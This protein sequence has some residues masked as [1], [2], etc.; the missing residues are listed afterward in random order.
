M[1][2]V[3]NCKI[4]GVSSTKVGKYLESIF[5]TNQTAIVSY[6]ETALSEKFA[7]FYK[8]VTGRELDLEKEDIKDLGPKII[9]FHNLLHRDIN[10]TTSFVNNSKFSSVSARELGKRICANFISSFYWQANVIKRY[11]DGK[12]IGKE[13]TKQDYI[14][15]V[16]A[17]IK[18]LVEERYKELVKDE[19]FKAIS[20]KVA[21]DNEGSTDVKRTE[22]M[23]RTHVLF[24]SKLIQD[25]NL[26]A[27]YDE[28]TTSAESKKLFFE[29]VFADNRLSYMS[30]EI[31]DQ[32]VNY[33][34][35]D[36]DDPDNPDTEGKR[37]SNEEKDSNDESTALWDGKL[38]THTNFLKHVDSFVRAYFNSIYKLKKTDITGKSFIEDTD[39]E[40]GIADCMDATECIATIYNRCSANSAEEMI[41]A[42]RLVA[43]EVPGMEGFSTVAD[44]LESNSDMAKYFYTVFGKSIVS[45]NEI[46]SSDGSTGTRISNITA[47]RNQALRMKFFNSLKNTSINNEHKYYLDELENIKN[48]ISYKINNELDR[49]SIEG[50]HRA[51]SKFDLS[52]LESIKNENIKE[53]EKAKHEF[54][55]KK[56]ENLRR[57]LNYRIYE[58]ISKY[59]PNISENTINSYIY[60]KGFDINPETNKYYYIERANNL[61]SLISSL[62]KSAE[63]TEANYYSLKIEIG[64]ARELKRKL[65]NDKSKF[66]YEAV[67]A[68]GREISRLYGESYLTQDTQSAA[69]ALADELIDFMVVRS[70]LNSRN[71]HGN[72]SSDVINNNMITNIIR[73]LNSPGNV[74]LKNFGNYKFKS[75]QY[76]FSN[77]MKEKKE[78]G[79]IVNYGLFKTDDNNELIIGPDGKYVETDYAKDLLQIELFS[80]ANNQDTNTAALYSEMSKGDFVVSAFTAFF[81]SSVTYSSNSEIKFANYFTRIP[82]DAPKIFTIKAPRYSYYNEKTG[83]LFNIK[84]SKELED[85][86]S[87]KLVFKHTLI[88]ENDPVYD[89]GDATKMS[90]DQTAR[91]IAGK[92]DK[93]IYI[94]PPKFQEKDY[95][96]GDTVHIVCITNQGENE[97]DFYYLISATYNKVNGKIELSDIKFEEALDIENLDKAEL[98]EGLDETTRDYLRKEYIANGWN[99]ARGHHTVNREINRNHPIYK[100]LFNLAKQEY[101]DA[102]VAIHKL[103][104][105]DENGVIKP[106]ANLKPTIREKYIN[107][108][109]LTYQ[110]YHHGMRKSPEGNAIEQGII[111]DGK[112]TGKV[113]TSD[114]FTL[115]DEETKKE[116]NYGQEL[117]GR[118]IDFLSTGVNALHFTVDS[119]DRVTVNLTEAQT[120]AINKMLEEYISDYINDCVSRTEQYQSFFDRIYSYE[121]VAE[122]ALNYQLMY[123]NFNDLLEG[124][125]KF[126]KNAQDFLKRAKETQ[127][128]GIPYG[129]ANFNEPLDAPKTEKDS[130]LNTDAIEVDYG[131]DAVKL[132]Y[133]KKRRV[134]LYNRF[135]GVTIKNTIR[136]S[137]DSQSEALISN[138]I[139]SGMT[140]KDA[141]A[142][143]KG[144]RNTKTNDAQSYITY[145]EWIR[146]IVAKGQ[147]AKYANLISKLNAKDKNGNYVPLKVEDID[148]FVQ[149]Q[150]N[151]YYDQHYDEELGIIVPRQIKNAEFVLIP[152]FIQGTELQEVYDLMM[153][154]NIDQL[155][156]QEAS[157]AGKRKVLTIWNDEGKITDESRRDFKNNVDSAKEEYNYNYLYT[158]QETPQ[159]MDSENKAGIQLMKKILDNITEDSP[160]Y[161]HKEKL[162][163]MYCANIKSSFVS[164]M[165]SLH[166]PLDENGNIKLNKVVREHE[167]YNEDGTVSVEEVESY[168]IAGLNTDLLYDRLREEAERLGVNS[169]ELD[170]F[171]TDEFGNPK[172]KSYFS[173][174]DS[175]L[176]SITQS[177]FNSRITKQKLPGFHAA[178]VTSVGWSTNNATIQYRLKESE[179]G[180]GF[181]DVISEEEYKKLPIKNRWRYEKFKGDIGAS[182]ELRYHPD[183]KPYIEVIIPKPAC[184]EDMSDEEALKLMQ[185]EKL[186]EFIGYRIPTEGKQSIA[187]MK[188]VR[189]T[190]KAQGSTIIVPDDWVSQTGADFDIDSVYAI[191]HRMRL[192]NGKLVRDEYDTSDEPSAR[193]RRYANYIA[194]CF[195]DLN[196]TFDYPSYD[197]EQLKVFKDRISLS[198]QDQIDKFNEESKK[199]IDEYFEKEKDL[200][201]NL[202]KE[203]KEALKEL[204]KQYTYVDKKGK[205]HT[206]WTQIVEETLKHFENKELNDAQKEYYE[207]Y[208]A[209]DSI[210]NNR[211]KFFVELGKAKHQ[212]LI[213]NLL[214]LKRK[215]I[216]N[217]VKALTEDKKFTILSFDE[218]INLPIEEQ[219]TKYARDG[220]IIDAMLMIL[221]DIS[222]LEENLSRS[223]FDDIIDARDGIKDKDGNW[224]QRPCMDDAT[225]NRRKSRSSYNFFDQA[226][227]QEDAM[228]GAKLK[229]FSVTQDNFCSI[230]NTVR[231]K[232]SKTIDVL[233][234]G[235]KHK[236]EDLIKTFG[237]DNVRKVTRKNGRTDYVVTHD[238]IGWSLTNKN[239]E[240]K[241]LT[242]YSSQTT[243]HILDAIKEGAIPNVNDL[244]FGVYKLFPN[245]G[246]NYQ[247]AVSFMMQPGVSR[248]VEAY[249][250]NKSIFN[251]DN[252]SVYTEV[253]IK[254]IAQE[255]GVNVDIH[256]PMSEV[257]KGLDVFKDIFIKTFGINP[258]HQ[259]EDSV[260]P[261]KL[262]LEEHNTSE[263]MFSS[264][265]MI[266]RLRN[267]GMFAST[268]P[269]E[270]PIIQQRRLLFDLYVVMQYHRLS[271]ISRSVT[272]IARCTNPDKFGAKQTV[273][274]TRKVISDIKKL[275]DNN[276]L[277]VEKGD[278]NVHIL[279][280]IYPGI[281]GDYASYLTN[282]DKSS[283]P[284]L[285]SFLKYSTVTSILVAEKVFDT[286]KSQFVK[287][288]GDLD[289]YLSGNITEKIY[290]DFQNYILA[291]VYRN[292]DCINGNDEKEV[293]RIC[294]YGKDIDY[295]LDIDFSQDISSKEFDE[296]FEEFKKLTPA[297]KVMLIQEHYREA[298]IFKYLEVNVSNERS[299]YRN[300][301]SEQRITFNSDTVDIEVAL[302]E[303]KK[304]YF[305]EDRIIRNATEDLIKYAIV[306]EGFK[307]RKNGISRSV[308]NDAL[309]DMGFVNEVDSYFKTKIVAAVND[310]EYREKLYTNYIRSHSKMSQIKTIKN[311]RDKNKRYKIP[312]IAYGIIS[313][314]A[315]NS[316]LALNTGIVESI[317]EKFSYP[318]FIKVVN[319]KNVTLYKSFLNSKGELYYYP[320]NLLEENE[321]TTWSSNQ[322]NNIY[323]QEKF[324]KELLALTDKLDVLPYSDYKDEYE[325]NRYV[326]QT[327]NKSIKFNI[328]KPESDEVHAFEQIKNDIIE[329]DREGRVL[330]Y[331][332]IN[333]NVDK[334]FEN[335]RGV[336][337]EQ[338]IDGKTYIFRRKKSNLVK[339]YVLN[340]N[341]DVNKVK[342]PYLR[343]IIEQYREYNLKPNNKSVF[344][345]MQVEHKKE[346]APVVDTPMSS[347]IEDVFDEQ[348]LN[349]QRD[350]IHGDMDAGKNLKLLADLGVTK[351]NKQSISDNLDAVSRIMKDRIVIKTQ[352][353]LG[354]IESFMQLD[355]D[356]Y[357]PIDSDE[358]MEAIK[359]DKKLQNAF[360]NVLLEAE[361]LM[362]DNIIFEHVSADDYEIDNNIKQINNAVDRL[363]KNNTLNNAFVK[364]GNTVVSS[365]S[366]DPLVQAGWLA[367]T[368]GYTNVSKLESWITSAK[369]SGIPVMQIILKEFSS[370]ISSSEFQA[371][372]RV[373]QYRKTREDI[374]NRAKAAG[375]TVDYKNFID[376]NGVFVQKYK[377]ELVDKVN[378]LYDNLSY[379]ETNYGKGSYEYVM[380]YREIA[381]F[382]LEHFNQEVDDKY[383]KT[384]LDLEETMLNR[385]RGIYLE[386]KKLEAERN[387]IYSHVTNNI[388][389]DVYKEKLKQVNDKIDALRSVANADKTAIKPDI[390]E[391]F[392]MTKYDPNNPDHVKKAINTKQHAEA[393]NNYIS[394][395]RRLEKEYFDYPAVEGFYEELK[396]NL[397][398]MYK[399]EKRNSR[400]EIT[401]LP[402]VLAAN[403][404]YMEAK[405]WVEKNARLVIRDDIKKLVDDAFKAFTVSGKTK[406]S[407]FKLLCKQKEAYDK[408]SVVDGRVFT[409]E[410]I[411]SIRDEQIKEYEEKRSSN[412]SDKKL[413]RNNTFGNIVWNTAFY[414]GMSSDSASNDTYIELVIKI[415]K[416]LQK[417][418]D[419]VQ[420]R[421]FTSELSID[422]LEKLEKLYDQLREIKPNHRSKSASKRIA[423]FI[424]ENVEFTHDTITYNQERARAASKGAEYL[425]A[426]DLANGEESEDG[427]WVPTRFL[428]SI[429]MPKG[430]QFE[431][432]RDPK[433]GAITELK[434][435]SVFDR[436]V[437][438]SKTMA[439]DVF[440]KFLSF[441][442]TSYYYQKIDEMIEKAHKANDP[443][444]YQKWY[445]ANHIYNPSTGVME[446]IKCWIKVNYKGA[447]Y[448]SFTSSENSDAVYNYVPSF[449]QTHK[450]TKVRN[451]LYDANLGLLGNYKLNTGYD[452]KSYNLN[453]YEEELRTLMTNTLNEFA[454]TDK[455]SRYIKRGNLPS[456]AR[457]K[458]KTAKESVTKVGK[459]A[460]SL[461]GIVLDDRTNP[462]YH[463]VVDYRHDMPSQVPMLTMLRNSEYK[464]EEK[465][466]SN[467][468]EKTKHEI[469]ERNKAIREHN[470]KIHSDML[471][472][473]WDEVM[474]EFIIRAANYN[475]IQ[476]NKYLLFYAKEMLRKLQTYKTSGLFKQELI[477]DKLRSGE[478]GNE[479]VKQSIKNAED[480]FDTIVRRL[481]YNE[482]KKPQG[483]A[484]RIGNLLQNVSSAKYMMVN[485]TGG[486]AN[487]TYG[488]TQIA[489]EHMFAKTYFNTK[490]WAIGKA[491][492]MQAMSSHLY[493][494]KSGKA[495]N[496]PDG[497]VKL[498]DVIDFDTVNGLAEASSPESWMSTFRSSLYGLQSVGEYFM[499]NGA[500]LSMMNSHRLVLGEDSK[501]HIW[502]LNRYLRDADDVALQQVISENETLMNEY[503]SFKK[504]VMSED[505]IMK[506]YA[507]RKRTPTE[508]FARYILSKNDEMFNKWKELRNKIKKERKESFENDETHPTLYSQFTLTEDGYATFA[509]DSILNDP[510]KIDRKEAFKLLASFRHETISVNQKIHGIYDKIGAASIE[511]EWWG[512]FVMQYHKHLY[513]G[514]MKRFRRKGYFNEERDTIERGCYTALFDF[515]SVEFN[516][517]KY[518]FMSDS[519]R[520]H[521]TGIQNLFKGLTDTI[522]NWK[523]NWSV[524]DDS[525]KAN[526][527]RALND[528]CGWLSAIAISVATRLML[529]DDDEE[530]AEGFCYN[531][532][533]YLAD[534][535]ASESIMYAL[536][537]SEAKKLWS[538]PVAA[539]QG[540]NDYLHVMGIL[541]QALIEGEDFNPEYQSGAYA[542]EN[543]VKV[544][545]MR[546]I[547]VYRSINQ[548]N[549][550]SKNNKYYRVDTNW[551]EK[552]SIY[553]SDFIKD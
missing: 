230:C 244:T 466:P 2:P 22:F 74:A 334:H 170:Y 505:D 509:P 371:K 117:I 456:R 390:N 88:G 349:V 393:L 105:H 474:E 248:V 446:P 84:N 292:A 252:S 368:D 404:T 348:I 75:H 182:K 441:D 173:I 153:D 286:Q 196:E 417:V 201:N 203:D 467:A 367:I 20:D 448:E 499:Q 51:I 363:R 288:V 387:E 395:I 412:L 115:F 186:D 49:N 493:N 144:Y 42:I 309:I 552:I 121:E 217:Q 319:K 38:G 59:I 400:F 245:I 6:Y 262:N 266:D 316:E 526:I 549:R 10:N 306:S 95:K 238:K 76:N 113:F 175:K 192:I 534:R 373:V 553:I 110:I 149:V 520:E 222:T 486:I 151:F 41:E 43:K 45:K 54:E 347:T 239:V 261:F 464:E 56:L 85:A 65:E 340:R 514:F 386:Y 184:F 358:V 434:G 47:N 189:F 187:V 36:S 255:L 111:E 398:I 28:M 297:Q 540:L 344:Y 461:L 413:I 48:L 274:A 190:N 436:F 501:Y 314:G 161:A 510:K 403:E 221:R 359:K 444:I 268:T 11:K 91:I 3:V 528:I 495:S 163:K 402:E 176:E 142:L 357:V 210:I 264:E 25:N 346:V 16:H 438:R 152:R 469:R 407:T 131:W 332:F 204:Q 380:A 256:T 188:V 439:I 527:M 481:L 364:F 283:Y 336:E 325:K 159:H 234:D 425:K 291:D 249:N 218:F 87:R 211:S 109:R 257:W 169:N 524:L 424:E 231:P 135:T 419:P 317:G 379:A 491:L 315:L 150:K 58:V 137:A 132:K 397:N 498:M 164:L 408:Q 4:N 471:D 320:L 82:S 148:E 335:A 389:D 19:K 208:K 427:E 321:N 70:D 488:E 465:I 414:R 401:E 136:T 496:L 162:I 53:K 543:K 308:A 123:A 174:F 551:N 92:D 303:F 388:L 530:S 298:G 546:Q 52:A 295:D 14:N 322:S 107:D 550:L 324:Y 431:I 519:E 15:A 279:D 214:R 339:K 536:P 102:A 277:Y 361:A 392:R 522:V 254:R 531:L 62:I 118:D 116:R 154:N 472:N 81:N 93:K 420:K 483:N 260:V 463:D 251:K 126:Y 80:G 39:N 200:Y 68:A 146:R 241:I 500:L 104:E 72:M 507:W 518:N 158:Q 331:N 270:E 341:L 120:N 69:I 421:V 223:N 193:I 220:E 207:L 71:V 147:Y 327:V 287:L 97:E 66:D 352:I 405:K 112:L 477:K 391:V 275:R 300:S 506:D 293:S 278:K 226:D 502:T 437:N 365:W 541:S 294:G 194:N 409:D 44:N 480:L 202:T 273:Y 5:G 30:K 455:A 98:G 457:A 108:P 37:E 100:Q 247:T 517:R 212:T 21:K 433:T 296:T 416:I 473:N 219:N 538:S 46:Y 475:A 127:G 265:L 165:R 130:I 497:I 209:F 377:Q 216:E 383:Y 259:F 356:T 382:K 494:F 547:P 422:D 177:L 443:S 508:D 13:W 12:L 114:R 32:D 385:Y 183:G 7:K 155:N 64:K 399:Y 490:D 27:L 311:T 29:E 487:V 521:M 17:R 99:D 305:N 513:P 125:T 503:K 442:K 525:E 128:S 213:D 374:I 284:P 418:Y 343:H 198:Y 476:E 423:K 307:M 129:I 77:I 35:S 243:A 227:Y 225:I 342:S 458:E 529:D 253:A 90:V 353:L 24:A 511:Q 172:M 199:L 280:A 313:L 26:A 143:L 197:K 523:L 449:N 122:F 96:N 240:N 50:L 57:D 318:D 250:R 101:V 450:E 354:K 8:D 233:Y 94:K 462:M 272:D 166:V 141:V 235:S 232:L 86:I 63:S 435:N 282:T 299:N 140:R 103:F 535:L 533:I 410:D 492:V 206:K 138:L 485:I 396:K 415:N 362:T 205:K 459:D 376:K 33:E 236:E 83:N 246:S 355:D 78:N 544:M 372:E 263:L 426:W 394:S 179:K 237:K 460:A 432:L 440:D 60:D 454:T 178:Q 119:N 366:D 229:A 302:N 351:N 180:K 350:A 133:T 31:T 34:E 55:V 61:V 224:I 242:C 548:V 330:V 156:T 301:L 145:E 452:N 478:D 67:I 329:W 185:E 160:L 134:K 489:M 168:E 468:D 228:S 304:C 40:F 470:M 451:P 516:D 276:I 542:G 539:E 312:T 290:K 430:V 515:L 267:E 73:T 191:M 333:Y 289:V 447:N 482:F 504:K 453:P 271:G 512:G 89:I 369:E 310:I 484:T 167:V 384:K 370:N 79:V 1:K 215:E 124:D 445:D 269:V 479:Y 378:E 345:V 406:S 157:K 337:S 328:N 428:Y 18:K 381:K 23:Q 360:L 429:A 171:T 106:D 139:K 281:Y 326:R 411:K 258:E 323:A 181:D 285:N 532:L 375:H 195:N 537:M 545:L 9:H 338:Q